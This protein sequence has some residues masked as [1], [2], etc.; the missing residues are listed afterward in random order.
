MFS[1]VMAL[2]ATVA[3]IGF[4]TWSSWCRVR[5][6]TAA[7][8]L[9]TRWAELHRQDEVDGAM[10]G[11]HAGAASSGKDSAASRLKTVSHHPEEVTIPPPEEQGGEMGGDT[12]DDGALFAASQLDALREAYWPGESQ[13]SVRA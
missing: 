2:S 13:S 6:L 1:L 9:A 12:R 11:V 4:I 7:R 10:D 8:G 5:R 3:A